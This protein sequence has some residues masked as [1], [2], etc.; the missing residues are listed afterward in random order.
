MHVSL[1]LQI[2]QWPMF[3]ARQPPRLSTATPRCLYLVIKPRRYSTS[4]T[5][6]RASPAN[7]ASIAAPSMSWP[8]TA[9]PWITV[10]DRPPSAECAQSTH[11]SRPIDPR[12]CWTASERI[13][14]QNVPSAA[15]CWRWANPG[16][17]TS[18]TCCRL[19]GKTAPNLDTKA[20]SR[21]GSWAAPS[22]GNCFNE[23]LQ[24]SPN[25][26]RKNIY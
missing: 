10:R 19:P 9:A 20:R 24:C 3:T 22:T 15:T 1:S 11:C 21:T 16:G 5:L 13:W 25:M 2:R 18:R 17:M 6:Q 8:P 12:P 7:A 4:G 23:L 26:A 14:W